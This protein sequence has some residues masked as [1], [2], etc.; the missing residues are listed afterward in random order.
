MKCN[1]SHSLY[2][3]ANCFVFD[4]YLFFFFGRAR[5][6][7]QTNA[8][9]KRRLSHDVCIVGAPPD[10]ADLVIRMLLHGYESDDGRARKL[11]EQGETRVLTGN[12]VVLLKLNGT[13]MPVKIHQA[14]CTKEWQLK[15]T[16]GLLSENFMQL[17]L[18]DPCNNVCN[19]GVCPNLVA[20]AARANGCSTPESSVACFPSAQD[21]F[22]AYTDEQIHRLLVAGHTLDATLSSLKNLLA[23]G[24]KFQSIAVLTAEVERS[25]CATSQGA[26]DVKIASEPPK[27]IAVSEVLVSPVSETSQGALDVKIASEPSKP[28]AVSKVVVS[29]K[30]ARKRAKAKKRASINSELEAKTATVLTSKNAQKQKHS[31]A[32]K[33]DADSQ[34]VAAFLTEKEG[35]QLFS[36]VP[37][38]YSLL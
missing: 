5:C 12:S 24:R 20:D 23:N 6:R 30:K 7:Y 13:L 34:I 1:N 25:T 10:F 27:A 17:C 26:H 8:Q 19:C 28:I 16:N 2:V 11:R 35:S 38:A 33:Q 22:L 29:P 21:D 4:W 18:P 15:A 36:R 31:Q 9:A 37:C 3:L 32:E 14:R